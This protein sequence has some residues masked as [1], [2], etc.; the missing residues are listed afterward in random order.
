MEIVYP[1]VAGI[2]VGKKVVAVAVRTPGDQPG[3]RHQQLRKY[4]TFYPTLREMVGWLV[5]QAVTHVAMEATGVYG[6]PVFHVLCEVESLDV[7]LVNARHV[8]NVPGRKTDAKDAE[9]LAELCEVGL[10]RGSFIPPKEIAA[11]RELTRYRK[12]LTEARTS[13]LQRLCKVLE[14]GGIKLDSVA[15]S[16]TTLSARAMVEAL[17][18]GERDPRVLADLA[19]GVMRKKIPDLTMALAGRF[20][21]QHALL[22]RMHLGH[23]DHLSGM[24][25]TLDGEIEQVITPYLC[26][27]PVSTRVEMIEDSLLPGDGPGT[28]AAAGVKVERPQQREDERP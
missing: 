3:Q 20:G 15:S 25:Q 27:T 1:R 24:I 4:R 16:I 18:G 26:G 9:W 13:E 2:D 7:L 23:I 22:A 6:K 5:D 14:D 12:K 11:I 17:I 28:M 8:K 10:L 21:A 19:R